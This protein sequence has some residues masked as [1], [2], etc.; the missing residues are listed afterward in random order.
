[1][2]QFKA[3]LQKHKMD[4]QNE[5][6][7]LLR[8]REIEI[9]HIRDIRELYYRKLEKVVQM[10]LELTSV[11]QQWEVKQCGRKREIPSKMRFSRAFIKKN[12]RRKSTHSTT[13]TSPEHSLTSPDSP[14]IVSY[15]FK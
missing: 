7:Q 15:V 10:Q 11:K 14:Q 9:K 12:E 13:P 8:T 5:H 6:E 4:I 1:M 3:Y 2:T